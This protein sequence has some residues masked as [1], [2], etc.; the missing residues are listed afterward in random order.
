M[1]PYVTQ[2]AMAVTSIVTV[3]ALIAADVSGS[4]VLWSTVLV[5]IVTWALVHLAAIWVR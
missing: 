3:G 4:T 5:S 2:A 1:F